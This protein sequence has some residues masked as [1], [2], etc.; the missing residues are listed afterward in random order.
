M[1]EVADRLRSALADRY[2]VERE[3][4]QGGMATVFLAHDLRHDRQVALKVLHSELAHAVGPGR[5]LREIRTT[6]RL[7]HPHI[8]PVFDSGEAD[9]QLWYAM[10]FVEG[11]SLR[12][13]LGR[14]PKLPIEDALQIAGEVADALAYAHERGIIHR[15]V[16]PENILLS[17]STREKGATDPVPSGRVHALVADFGI[18]RAVSQ[19]DGDK[20]TGTGLAL[21][22]PAYMSPEQAAGSGALDG[23]SDQYSL[24][25]VLYEMLAGVQPF[26]GPT[27]QA[28]IARRF[29]EPPRALRSLR[30]EVPESL[31]RVVL[32]AL[33]R[34][35]VDRFPSAAA[36]AEALAA[37]KAAGLPA[38]A[39]TMRVDAQRS[40]LQL[41][42]RRR[43]LLGLVVLL[44]AVTI[45][46]DAFLRQRSGS[47]PSLD[48]HLIAVAPFEVLVPGL[49]VWREGLMDH[50]ARAL[51]GAGALRAVPPTTVL[52]RWRGR[53][54]SAGALAL[55]HR[56]GAGLVVYGQLL[57]IGHDSVGVV[58]KVVDARSGS[59]VAEAQ[60]A[61]L[62]E[63][64][65]RAGDAIAVEIMGRTWTA[66]RTE[67]RV[68]SQLGSRSPIAMR[69]FLGGEQFYRRGM[70][71]S[72]V[73]RYKEAIETDTSFI[74]AYWHLGRI[75]SWH[76]GEDPRP[77]IHRAVAHARGLDPKNRALMISDSIAVAVRS[78][79]VPL[80]RWTTSTRVLGMLQGAASRDPRD[81]QV[82]YEL[83]EA[84]YHW[85]DASGALG[86][87]ERAIALD[88]LFAPAY[89]HAVELKL[90]QGD[91]AGALRYFDRLRALEADMPPGTTA[92]VQRYLLR[93]A[94]SGNPVSED[95]VNVGDLRFALTNEFQSWPDSGPTT[96]SMARALVR[97]IGTDPSAQG[98]ADSALAAQVLAYRGHV[99]E[100]GGLGDNN[101][102]VLLE[103]GLIGAVSAKRIERALRSP[104]TR[105]GDMP[106]EAAPWWA[107]RRDTAALR[108]IAARGEHPGVNARA[109]A[110]GLNASAY[111]ALARRDTARALRSFMILTDTLFPGSLM[112]SY[113]MGVL[114]R[115]RLLAAIG[116]LDQ[117]W[118][119]H[120]GVLGTAASPG[121]ARVVM[122]LELGE[123]A[124]RQGRRDEALELYRFVTA[125]W[126]SADPVL[127]GYVARARAGLA[128]LEAQPSADSS[129]TGK[130]PS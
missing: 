24:G 85:D 52:R 43:L 115:A 69:A 68:L 3:V 32:R 28:V 106:L 1:T 57:R 19:T 89:L 130:Q 129:T 53:A 100:A 84:L 99:I 38:L 17:G 29:M 87:F 62:A 117:A 113:T 20:L 74:L 94:V 91:P 23:R 79:P 88:S 76:E 2:V 71:D 75:F 15:D 13:R 21:G 118:R 77:F 54:D 12:G 33:A 49:E 65:D 63:H 46:A 78:S 36:F 120:E 5:F 48:D 86:N 128:R 83:G 67:R 59:V 96:I 125:I 58:A 103:L 98:K 26:T 22:T 41:L 35:P 4:G 110:A 72:A 18:A 56:T 105:A 61:D 39:P 51:D 126:H 27:P 44:T 116:D 121:P 10:P 7:Q 9:G 111:L 93:A 50:L 6:A 70:L 102:P 40:S 81:P 66:Q 123:L 45:G 101:L 90:N 104:A 119:L 82:W 42:R 73:A 80:S 122:R 108:R 14:Q 11:E 112:A 92:S 124:E 34:E 60:G 97:K 114:E 47:K 107:T 37:V 8:L 109:L 55:A 16:K 127:Q 25:C 95:S 30:A 64:V 31:D